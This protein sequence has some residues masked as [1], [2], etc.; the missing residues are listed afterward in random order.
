VYAA[1]E[2][3]LVV[4]LE[5]DTGDKLWEQATVEYG[6]ASLLVAGDDLFVARGSHVECLDRR[7][8]SSRWA[9]TVRGMGKGLASLAIPETSDDGG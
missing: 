6:H 4:C 5:A 2:E 9:K 3:E 8:G 7:T 1:S